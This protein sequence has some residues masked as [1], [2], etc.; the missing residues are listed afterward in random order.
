MLVTM[1]TAMY[2]LVRAVEQLG[3]RWVREQEPVPYLVSQP[4]PWQVHNVSLSRRGSRSEE[5]VGQRRNSL[6]AYRKQSSA[7]N[8]HTVASADKAAATIQN[9]Y[10]KYQQKKQKDHK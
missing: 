9:Q 2:M 10:R 8:G 7:S 4:L 3:V 6:G 1:L 5:F